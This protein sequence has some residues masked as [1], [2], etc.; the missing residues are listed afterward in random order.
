[1]GLVDSFELY[2]MMLERFGEIPH[3]KH[4]PKKFK[5]YVELLRESNGS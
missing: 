5:Y 3:P 2:T 1:M 4:Q